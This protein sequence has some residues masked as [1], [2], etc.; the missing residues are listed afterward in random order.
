MQWALARQNLAEHRGCDAQ[1]CHT[2][3]KY[4]VGLGETGAEAGAGADR[5]DAIS[6]VAWDPTRCLPARLLPDTNSLL[7]ESQING[8]LCGLDVLPRL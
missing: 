4:L 3:N 6:K 5:E 8:E 7:P 1:H 2:A